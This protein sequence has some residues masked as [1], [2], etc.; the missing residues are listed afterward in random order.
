[1]INFNSSNY[2]F[3]SISDNAKQSLEER[4]TRVKDILSADKDNKFRLGVALLE[5]YNSRVY[6]VKAQEY[7]AKTGYLLYSG[8]NCCSDIFF[9]YCTE[10]FGLEKSQ[11]SRYMNIVDEFGDWDKG[12]KPQWQEYSYSQLTELLPLSAEDRKNVKPDWTVKRIRAYK[13]NLVATSQPSFNILNDPNEP[14]V[15]TSQQDSID[16]KRINEICTFRGSPVK[17]PLSDSNHDYTCYDKFRGMSLKSI[18]DMLLRAQ[19]SLDKRLDAVLD[20][21]V[22]IFNTVNHSAE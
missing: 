13:K 17:I 7:K 19:D 1:M 5:I 21:Q 14:A 9:W 12:F 2:E 18:L 11:V 20:G 16:E 22:S 3:L 8:I 10:Y 4:A 6:R 15:A